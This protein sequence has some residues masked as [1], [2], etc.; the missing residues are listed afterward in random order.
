MVERVWKY[1]GKLLVNEDISLHVDSGE[2]VSLLGPNGAGKTT[3]VKQIYGE[4]KPDKGTIRVLGKDPNS[5]EVKRKMGIIPQ[6]TEPFEDLTVEDNIYFMGKLKGMKKDE[7]LRNL[8][9]LLEAL[10]L[11]DYRKKLARNLSGGLKRKLL[12]AMALV[13]DPEIVIMDEPTTGLDP[14]SRREV[15]EILDKIRKDGRGILL[16]TH[17]MEEAERLSDR[18]YFINRR[19]IAEGTTHEIKEKFSSWY[20]VYDYSTG[21]IYRVRTEEIKDFLMKLNGKFEVR[22]PSLEEVYLKVVKND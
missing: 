19:I 17:Y 3:L 8:R 16:T 12:I 15:W 4:L 22:L 14:I 2:I 13:N 6:E 1:F 11:E 7:V 10:G 20:E 18:I 21:N 5:I 9:N